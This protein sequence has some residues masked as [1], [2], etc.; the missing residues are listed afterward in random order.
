[1]LGQA[2]GSPRRTPGAHRPRGQVPGRRVPLAGRPSPDL[3]LT[4]RAPGCVHCLSSS[5]PPR[6]W[7]SAASADP[8]S[9]GSADAGV[10][11][12]HR[13]GRPSRPDFW[14]L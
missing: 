11:R 7:L 1:V 14:D 3:E 4:T 5:G 2:R 6:A 10:L 8:S 13:R 9:T 12:E